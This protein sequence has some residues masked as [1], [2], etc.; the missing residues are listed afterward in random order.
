MFSLPWF[1]FLK[2][3][4]NIFLWLVYVYS[5]WNAVTI[6]QFLKGLVQLGFMKWSFSL[7]NFSFILWIFKYICQ[8]LLE[9]RLWKDDDK[10]GNIILI[11][12]NIKLWYKGQGSSGP[13][14][15]PYQNHQGSGDIQALVPLQ[16]NWEYRV[17]LRC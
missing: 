2:T 4:I 16:I 1:H 8:L 7:S 9:K 14:S 13:E 17:G 15:R 6:I 12:W 10:S 3:P 5:N 11:F